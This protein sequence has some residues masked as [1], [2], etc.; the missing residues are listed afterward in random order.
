MN[1]GSPA[2]GSAAT[3]G[4]RRREA[5][6][7]EVHQAPPV[8]RLERLP[9]A[10]DARR[11]VD[12][13][14]QVAAHPRL[15]ALRVLRLERSLTRA[16]LRRDD[17]DSG[18]PL[19]VRGNPDRERQPVGVESRGLARGDGRRPGE[20]PAVIAERE[21]P[22]LHLGRVATL[23]RKRVLHLEQVGEIAARVDPDL[24]RDRLVEVIQD[25]E[26]LVEPGGDRA[27]PDH[28]ELRVDVDRAGSRHEEEARLE[29]LQ[30][31]DRER[32]EPLPVH[33]EH[34]AR[35]EARVEGEEPGRIGERRLDVAVASRSRRRCCRR[36]S[37]RARRSR[38]R[39]P[40]ARGRGLGKSRC[41]RTRR[42]Q[43]PSTSRS[44]RRTAATAFR[45]PAAILSKTTLSARTTQLASPLLAVT[46]RLPLS[47]VTSQRRVRRPSTMS[48]RVRP[49]AFRNSGSCVRSASSAKKCAVGSMVGFATSHKPSTPESRPSL[50]SHPRPRTAWQ[51]ASR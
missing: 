49:S 33:R 21:L 26:L 9:V 36:G 8:R 30:V 42:R 24:E 1:Q 22:P 41:I 50:Q 51:V 28:R 34:P 45:R 43:S 37:S 25:R 40:S 39:L 46:A 44:P 18:R 4:D 7:R 11:L 23:L 17:V 14:L 20:R 31:V 35:Q 2:A 16:Q 10:L 27:L 19:A 47:T 3:A 32:V 5:Q 15:D 48:K 13:A 38:R 29:V 12:P 6:R